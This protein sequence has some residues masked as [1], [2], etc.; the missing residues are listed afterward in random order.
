MTLGAR[1]SSLRGSRILHGSAWV[2]VG[3]VVQAGLGFAFWTLAARVASVDDV[4]RASTLFT[5]VQFVNYATGLG[6]TVMLARFAA[7]RSVDTERLY[8]WS[9]VAGALSS[10]VGAVAFAVLG[11]DA[12][13]RLVVGSPWSIAVFAF[14][15]AGISVGLL[16]DVRFMAER[17]W[18]WLIGRV[19]VVGVI[20][21]PLLLV[22]HAAGDD[23]WL[24]HLMLAPLAIGGW[25]SVPL[26]AAID[27]G[28]PRLGRIQDWRP[29]V[30]FAGVNWAAALASTAP[31]FVLPL[32]V[33]AEVPAST[34]AG[35]F[36]AWTITGLVLLVPGAIS[37]ILL[38]EGARTD[39]GESAVA[40]DPSG[41]RATGEDASLADH[42]RQ[43]LRFSVGIAVLA[44][45][46]AFAGGR[47]LTMVL[48]DGY[49][50]LAAALPSL[51]GAG[52]PWAIT[53][54]RLS[55]ARLRHDQTA[56]IVVTAV[57][58]VGILG[59]AAVWIPAW[60][61]A[62]ATRAWLLGNVAAAVVAEAMDRRPR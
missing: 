17:R 22:P 57:L 29:P 24:Y 11:S 12:S 40:P 33:T 23:T 50:V 34:Y 37:Q 56:T 54:V 48:G 10:V 20:R 30:E 9:L 61:V 16:A 2:L 4:G 52:I 55:E 1:I 59:P 6:L 18:G 8:G 19:A 28:R 38:V 5:I 58:G 21:L 7:V 62:G 3:L 53:S 42:A 35:F 44:W 45:V 13:T 36:L 51:V 46:G 31:Q 41:G 49:Q 43:A 32:I 25:L 39:A 15:V 47:L 27:A 14:Y 26:L 60:G